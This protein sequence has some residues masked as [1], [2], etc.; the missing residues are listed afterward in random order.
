MAGRESTGGNL[1]GPLYPANPLLRT[2]QGTSRSLREEDVLRPR[3]KCRSGE[4]AEEAIRDADVA[5]A[6]TNAPQPVVHGD[7]LRAGCHVNAIGA[8]R[9][10]TRELD[11]AAI[12]RC[13]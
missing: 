13:A 5:V 6:A 11:D 8:N 4:S 3:G 12:R 1:R 7:W 10:E 9:L 2:G